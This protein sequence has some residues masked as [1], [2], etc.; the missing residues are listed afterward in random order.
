VAA[1]VGSFWLGYYGYSHPSDLKGRAMNE[2]PL[3]AK[4]QAVVLMAWLVI[5]PIFFWFEYFGI[6]RPRQGYKSGDAPPADWEM[7]KYAQDISAKIWLAI[8]TT[9]L[10]LYFGKDIKL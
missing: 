1:L 3:H 8:S 4:L 10:I 7:F 2:W 6:Y 9:L 5:P